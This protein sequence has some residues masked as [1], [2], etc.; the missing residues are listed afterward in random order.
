MSAGKIDLS[1]MPP[2][3]C[4]MGP[5]A[6]G[7]T[8]LAIELSKRLP[9]DIISVDSAL[10][11]REMDI[12]TAKPS[13]QELREAPHRLI[14]ILDPSESYSVARFY[15][16]A[17]REMRKISERG[18]IPLLVG[19][20][21]MYFKVLRDG[22]AAMPS[23][24]EE[25]RREINALAADK[26]WPHIH[27]LLGEVDPE[28]AARIKPTD[29]QRLQRALEV[30]RVS[31]RTLTEH[32]RLQRSSKGG[33]GILG[34]DAPQEIKNNSLRTGNKDDA[35]YTISD[36]AIPPVSYR[37][38]SFAISPSE[39]KVLHDRIALRFRNMLDQGFQSE[40]ERLRARGNLNL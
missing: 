17:L 22:I 9:V 15:S 23:A 30:Y 7:K 33:S 4:L 12:G 32:W 25:V 31:G 18:R 38:I 20:T 35:D 26:G 8:D 6:S 13:A 34:E 1:Q 14:D 10:I 36:D 29:P 39:R 5:T 2:A 16:D 24:D 3:I 28:S 27:A 19:G 11:Y 40:V 37:L 21:M